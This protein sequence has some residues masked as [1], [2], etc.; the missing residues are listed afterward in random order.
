MEAEA[1]CVT[2]RQNRFVAEYAIDLNATQAAT[3]ATA[4]NRRH[5]GSRLLRNAKVSAAV[6]Q[7]TKQ[8]LAGLDLTG[9]TVLDAMRRQVVGDIR[10]LFD[11]DGKPDPD[12]PAPARGRGLDCRL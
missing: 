2:P 12:P 6:Q 1:Q 4:R 11:A 9:V 10:T 8:Q 3:A 7:R 5:Q